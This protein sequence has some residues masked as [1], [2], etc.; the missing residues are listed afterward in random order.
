MNLRTPLSTVRGLGTAHNGVHHWWLLRLS[1]IALIP[2]SVWLMVSLICVSTADHATAVAWLASPTGALFA[3]LFII[4]ATFH[5]QMGLQEVVVD[6]V[7]NKSCKLGALILIKLSAFAL[8]TL[9]ILAIVRM[10]L[11]A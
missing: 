4:A 10:S 3:V 9:C 1:A 2:L 8:A 11:G 5:G 7:H 6:Y